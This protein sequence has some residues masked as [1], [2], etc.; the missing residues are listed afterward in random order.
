[1]QFISH[2]YIQRWNN[3]KIFCYTVYREND[4]LSHQ[5]NFQSKKI[6]GTDQQLTKKIA[7]DDSFLWPLFLLRTR[8][9]VL[10]H[11]SY[12]LF[13]LCTFRFYSINKE[14][15]SCSRLPIISS[16]SFLTKNTK[17]GNHS[18]F[19]SVEIIAFSAILTT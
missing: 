10:I 13:V 14:I 8:I 1:M 11:S 19:S 18:L 17:F 12:S 3:G 5:V 6:E 16:N 4:D 7:L 2:T 9:I 15:S